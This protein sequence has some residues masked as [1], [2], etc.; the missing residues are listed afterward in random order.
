MPTGAPPMPNLKLVRRGK[1]RDV[2]ELPPDAEGPRLLMVAS[3]RVSA[4]DVVMPTPIPGKGRLLTE[5]AAWWFGFIERRRLAQTHLLS[6]S[7]DDLPPGAV[8]GPTREWLRGRM[9]IG[10]ACRVIPI[11]CVVRGYLEGSGWKE[12]QATGSVCGVAL[13]KG[14]RQCDKLPEPIF[15]PA[16]KAVVGH[17]E[18]IGFEQAAAIVGLET[19]GVLR[20]LSLS[21]Y[22]AAAEHAL[23][24][25]IIIA[26][27]KFE[28]G[29]PL[30]EVDK[31]QR[32]WTPPMLIDEALTPDSSRFWP[33]DGYTP[34]RAQKSFDKQFLREY[35]ETLVAEGKW[36]KTAPGPELPANVVEGTLARYREARERLCGTG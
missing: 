10:R 33:A 28:F 32:V 3:D 27:T 24:R 29:V 5:I 17:D 13:P 8:D 7:V 22:K 6:T 14:L 35:L 11:E 2:Y 20:E 18:N 1:V 16:T 4:F 15:T 25:G 26:D 21:I 12:Y 34:G 30:G 31:Q 19:A 36:N 9:T 23:S